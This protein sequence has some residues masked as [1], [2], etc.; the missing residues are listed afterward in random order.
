MGMKTTTLA[1]IAGMASRSRF[2]AW[3]GDTSALDRLPSGGA[4]ITCVAD[5][6]YLPDLFDVVLDANTGEI[7]KGRAIVMG[8]QTIAE[9]AEAEESA[10]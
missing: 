1:R 5:A 10:Q 6:R 8:L 3:V 9:K 2:V 7:V 4:R